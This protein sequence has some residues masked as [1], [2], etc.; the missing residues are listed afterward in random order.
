M[1]FEINK[2]IMWRF[3]SYKFYGDIERFWDNSYGGV[4]CFFLFYVVIV[5]ENFDFNF[6]YLLLVD[7]ISFYYI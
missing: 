7:C 3:D 6:V 1:E 4:R 2:V 5:G